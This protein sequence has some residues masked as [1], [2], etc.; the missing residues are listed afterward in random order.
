M[1]SQN[2]FWDFFVAIPLSF[3]PVPKIRETWKSF[4]FFFSKNK[5]IGTKGGNLPLLKMPSVLLQNHRQ[6]HPF[7]SFVHLN[8]FWLKTGFNLYKVQKYRYHLNP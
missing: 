1:K 8:Y 2:V 4:L 6:L 7:S 5:K 3:S